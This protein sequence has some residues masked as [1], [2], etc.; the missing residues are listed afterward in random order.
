MVSSVGSVV[1]GTASV[2]RSRPF[3]WILISQSISLRMFS[4]EEVDEREEKKIEWEE[5]GE[6]EKWEIEEREEEKG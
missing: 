4:A 3:A 2:G 5:E 1:K 6:E